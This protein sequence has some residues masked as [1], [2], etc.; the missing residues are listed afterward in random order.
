MSEEKLHQE[1]MNNG[2]VV[3]PKIPN[4]QFDNEQVQDGNQ[5]DGPTPIVKPEKPEE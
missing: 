3:D 4:D 2:G 5:S 1:K